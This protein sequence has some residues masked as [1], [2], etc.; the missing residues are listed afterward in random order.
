VDEEVDVYSLPTLPGTRVDDHDLIMICFMTLFANWDATSAIRSMNPY[1]KTIL[2][3]MTQHARM[4]RFQPHLQPEDHINDMFLPTQSHNELVYP[5]AASVIKGMSDETLGRAQVLL[6][7]MN[8]CL[9]MHASLS[10]SAS[11]KV[12]SLTPAKR[13]A[14]SPSASP[15][16]FSLYNDASTP[17]HVPVNLNLD[18]TEDEI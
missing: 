6:D 5:L 4:P 16:P 10:T 13:S 8:H 14:P 12:S 11:A 9:K 3:S 2:R 1:Y 17:T 18:L 15:A 7:K